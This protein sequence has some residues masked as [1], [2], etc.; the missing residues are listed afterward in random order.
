M[1]LELAQGLYLTESFYWDLNDRTR[2]FAKKVYPKTPNNMPAMGPAGCYAGTLH[3]LKTVAA[4]G[5]SAAKGSGRDVVARMKAMPCDDDAF[6]RYSIREDGQV[7]N[8]AYLFQVKTPAESHGAWDFYKLA[9][10]TPG[11]EAF[12]PMSEGHCPFV[13]A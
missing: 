7:L 4:M 12:R 3:F 6:G 2:A 9:A 13:R 1:G 8:N 10:T 11:S 5:V